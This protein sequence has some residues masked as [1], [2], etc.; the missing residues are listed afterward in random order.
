MLIRN[1]AAEVYFVSKHSALIGSGKVKVTVLD[2]TTG[3]QIK[4]YSLNADP[5]AVSVSRQFCASSCTGSPFLAWSE[6]PYRG[7]KIN[8]LGTSKMST[9]TFESHGGEEIE[10]LSMHFPCHL[11]ALPHFL[12]HLRSKTRHWAEIFHTDI[13][14]GEVSRAYSVPALGEG[15]AF[16]ASNIDANVYFTR[17]TETETLLYSS[18]SHGVLGRWPRSRKVSGKA[19]HIA[20]EVVSRGKS[21]FAIRVAVTSTF[22]EWALVR[23]GETVWTRPEMLANV[24]AAAWAD[25]MRGDASSHAIED[26]AL[27]SSLNAYIHRVKRHA[28]DLTA[29]PKWLQNLPQNILSSLS[30]A[31]AGRDK[32][33]IGNKI[34]IVGTSHQELLALDANAGGTIRWIRND[35]AEM[36]GLHAIRSLH[37]LAEHV[38]VYLS[39]GSVGAILNAT[40]GSIIGLKEQLPPFGRMLQVPGSSGP[41]TIRVLHDG[42]PQVAEDFNVSAPI[43]GNSIVTINDVGQAIGWAIGKSA[44]KLWTLRP[45]SGFKL[46]D[47]VGRASHDPVASIGNVLG[48]RSVLYKYLSPNLVL[49]TALSSDALTIYLV[50]SVTGAVL[51]TSTHEGVDS[52]VPVASVMSENWFAYSFL[53]SHGAESARGHQLVITELYESDLSNDRGVLGSTTNYSSFDAGATR[54]PYVISQSFTLPE[55]V[56]YMAVTQTTQGIT[57]RQLLCTLA[58]SNAIIGVPRHILAARRPVDRDATPLEAEEGLF[59]YSPI[60]EF[61]AKLLLTHS[62]EVLGVKKVISTPSLLE[63][64]SLVFAFGHD[65]FGTKVSPSGAFDILNKTFNKAQLLLTVVALAAGTGAL[66]PMVRKKTVESR[67]K[68]Q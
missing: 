21:G 64:T 49:L 7:L 41:V 40:D 68:G 15:S 16:T 26:E 1:S 12:V 8:L 32:R 61:D 35:F 43:E 25:D 50:E 58:N 3:K 36:N 46:V 20:S 65:I 10:D 34:L 18:A 11:D 2:V 57:I 28:Q 63:S 48:D 56:S 55:Q 60:L 54:K 23:N 45:S 5:D 51:Y 24:V 31:D 53:A 22:G 39:D 19:L 6:R 67:W 30:G 52:R 13:Q 44:R 27:S 66:A 62:R 42:T 14:S 9:L 17:A 33:M 37:V 59:K 47:A 4:Q 38:T 29:L